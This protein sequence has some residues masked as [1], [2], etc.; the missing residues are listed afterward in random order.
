VYFASLDSLSLITFKRLYTCLSFVDV[1]ST[2]GDLFELIAY[3]ITCNYQRGMD[4]CQ[5]FLDYS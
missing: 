1:G 5:I 2:T 3:Y 4:K